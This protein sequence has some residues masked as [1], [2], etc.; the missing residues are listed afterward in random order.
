MISKI[1][2]GLDIDGKPVSLKKVSEKD[3]NNL[4][5][6]SVEDHLN[7]DKSIQ[8]MHNKWFNN[9]LSVESVTVFSLMCA[10]VVFQL[11][12]RDYGFHD[13]EL[14]YTTIGDGWSFSN[15]EILPITP[16]YLRI[17]TFLFGYS[18]WVIHLAS[19]LCCAFILGIACLITKEFGGK[20]YAILLTGTF[21]LFSGLV[22]AASVFTY[23]APGH[24]IWIVALYGVVRALKGN[25]PRWAIL[26]GIFIGIGMLNKVTILF[27]P[28]ALV[29]S[30]IFVPQRAWF[31]SRWLWIAG[32]IAIPFIIPFI[33]WQ[34][35]HDWYFLDFVTK[36][37]GEM[38]Y[39]A[40]FPAFLWNQIVPNNVLS[41]PVW[42]IGLLLLLFSA[43]WRTYR[44]LGFTY[45]I[46]FLTFYLLHSPFYF[47]MPLYA[48]LLSVG[49]VRVEQYFIQ[50]D[51]PKSMVNRMKVAL[52]CLYV[53]GSLPLLPLALPI[54]PVEKLLIYA[55]KFGVDAGIRTGSSTQSVLPNWFAARFGWDEMVNEI[56]AVYHSANVAENNSVGIIAGNYQEASA[57]HFYRK[58][59][60]LPEPISMQ[61]WFYFETLRLH[62]FK[63]S[64]VSIGVSPDLLKQL[65][66]SVEQKGI[67]SNPYC[68]PGENNLP[69][70]FCT[71]PKCDL[72]RRW[73]IDRRMDPQFRKYI[74]A[75]GVIKAI[76]WYRE[77]KGKDN[78]I[79]LFTA[80][81]I[82]TLGYDYLGKGRYDEAIALFSLNVEEYPES[83]NVYDSMGEVYFTK[84]EYEPAG[85][86]YKES[87]RRDPANNNARQYLK[88]IDSIT[89]SDNN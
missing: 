71:G 10:A 33:V 76:D 36:Y 34:F 70:Y 12:L 82:N 19:A 37:T 63:P 65:F 32:F 86:F 77:L 31:R 48:I 67:F 46:L 50:S 54:L 73:I 39:K 29:I 56:S 78:T 21:L 13:D 1:D 58:K 87:L 26:T 51:S 8:N 53:L 6:V 57:V 28:L 79:L 44:L 23:D 69:V 43:K 84:G 64:Y 2:N 15:L 4:N 72:K 80:Q 16:L 11:L 81:Q 18:I 49:S 66:T 52:P 24:L 60:G 22:P 42:L 47:M 14:Y 62:E 7:I 27:L 3:I 74:D 17:F 68:Q 9:K 35:R 61:G 89:G 45:I 41:F 85:R 40:T 20:N 59:Y 5:S 25:N 30:L 55:D 38:S 75:K 88:R 83:S